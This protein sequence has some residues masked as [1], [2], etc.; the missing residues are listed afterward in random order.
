MHQIDCAMFFSS[1]FKF[2]ESLTPCDLVDL[3]DLVDISFFPHPPFLLP[4]H[5]TQELIKAMDSHALCD[6]GHCQIGQISWP[7]H[8]H[9]IPHIATHTLPGNAANVDPCLTSET[10]A[11]T[12]KIMPNNVNY[13]HH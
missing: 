8:N 1:L 6:S 7:C 12:D 2:V 11:M 5:L 10:T 3:V 9:T 4:I 13:Y